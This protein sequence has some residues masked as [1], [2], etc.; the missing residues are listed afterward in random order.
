MS[1][2]ARSVQPATS[3]TALQICRY[4]VTVVSYIA[5]GIKAEELSLKKLS[6]RLV[7][8]LALCNADRSSNLK[9]LDL[10]F[11]LYTPEEV[12]FQIPGLTK[13]RRSGPPREVSYKKFGNDES[14][15]PVHT[16]RV[17]EMKTSSY[18]K[19]SNCSSPLFISFKKPFQSVSA[20]SISRW[21]KELLA[22]AGMDRGIFKGHSVRA[23]STSAAKTRSVCLQDIIATAA[24][25][26]ASTFERFYAKPIEGN[27]YSSSILPNHS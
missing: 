14:L 1:V 22:E 25:S 5:N 8:L 27:N 18:R 23:A 3:S 16:L 2:F 9:A 21:T 24:W 20:A 19:E 12:R 7:V 17:Y 13:T 6:Q 11:R 26:R 10:K 15:C 4:T